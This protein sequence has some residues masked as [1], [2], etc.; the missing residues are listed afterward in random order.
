MG[1]KPLKERAFQIANPKRQNTVSSVDYT[2]NANAFQKER[3]IGVPCHNS[4]Q[5]IVE[6]G[7]RW[8]RMENRIACALVFMLIFPAVIA[9]GQSQ[10]TP[11]SDGA[12]HDDITDSAQRVYLDPQTGRLLRG[13]PPGVQ[14][15]PLSPAEIN[16][17]STSGEALKESSLQRGG[18]MLDLRGRFR[19]TAVATVADDGS[20]VISEVS[21]EVI[22]PAGP[23]QSEMHENDE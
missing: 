9:M 7:P 1:V 4:G 14:I 21:G 17:L 12:A 18:V 20:I 15:P 10:D 5:Q 19:S 16:M 22:S 6:R 8:L 3:C 23:E 13:P 11:M 2:I